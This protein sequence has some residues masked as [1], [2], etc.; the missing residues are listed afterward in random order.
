MGQLLGANNIQ[1]EELGSVAAIATAGATL[2]NIGSSIFGNR[3]NC[4]T[5]VKKTERK[6]RQLLSQYTTAQERYQF[7]SKFNAVQRIGT[8]PRDMAYFY[9][10]EDDCKHKNVSPSHQKFLDQL[11]PWLQQKVDENQQGNLI[12]SFGTADVLGGI[13]TFLMLSSFAYFGY[14]QLKNKV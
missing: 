4:S 8:S 5:K 13:G 1:D 12:S 2:F 14:E 6:V 7:V 10:G 3:D 9:I 11:M